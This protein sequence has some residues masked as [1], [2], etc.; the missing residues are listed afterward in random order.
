MT[1]MGHQV[2]VSDP[3]N[4]TRR[5]QSG[6]SFW[7]PWA[8]I[9]AATQPILILGA[10]WYLPS[11]HHLPAISHQPW[12]A[13]LV[14]LNAFVL[15]F[16]VPETWVVFPIPRRTEVRFDRRVTLRRRSLLHDE[17]RRLVTSRHVCPLHS[18]VPCYCGSL[19]RW[20]EEA[21]HV[22][23]PLTQSSSCP[24]IT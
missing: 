7:G 21:R 9:P 1:A 4:G 8:G 17:V 3:A 18:T 5:R 22:S 15:G 2:P 16:V 6:W 14:G 11:M 10:S 13:L 24:G 12:V 19:C 23:S 20:P